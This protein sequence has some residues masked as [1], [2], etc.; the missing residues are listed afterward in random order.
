MALQRSS[1]CLHTQLDH[2][3]GPWVALQTLAD[4]HTLTNTYSKAQTQS[5]ADST[6]WPFLSAL[7]QLCLRGSSGNSICCCCCCFG[8]ILKG[9]VNKLQLHI[10]AGW[11]SVRNNKGL[12]NHKMN[13]WCRSWILKTKESINVCFKSVSTSEHWALQLWK[14]TVPR[15]WFH[16]SVCAKSFW[17][18][19]KH[20]TY[21]CLWKGEP[22][23]CRCFYNVI[24]SLASF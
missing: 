11:C 9:R 14:S 15:N 17:F 5:L 22:R 20:L 10:L 6:R 7:H 13:R 12:L 18:E 23:H 16:L 1:F 21:K 3:F 2:P 19:A 4:A 8:D 24:K